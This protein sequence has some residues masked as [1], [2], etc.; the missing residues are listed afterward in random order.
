MALSLKFLYQKTKARY[1]LSLLTGKAGLSQSVSRIYQMEEPGDPKFLRGGELILTTGRSL[2]SPEALLSFVRTVHEKHACGIIFHMNDHLLTIPWDIITFCRDARFPLLTM[3]SD[4]SI[5]AVADTYCNELL[6][7]NAMDVKIQDAF[8]AI[9]L[10]GEADEEYLSFLYRAGYPEETSY[11]LAATKEELVSRDGFCFMEDAIHF[12]IIPQASGLPASLPAP[13]G[14]VKIPDIHSL[15]AGKKYA[16]EAFLI[17]TVSNRP[18]T[19]YNRIDFFR[20]LSSVSDRAKLRNFALPALQPLLDHDRLHGTGYLS[21]LRTYLECDGNVRTVS[22]NTATHYSTIDYRLRKIS[23][24]LDTD[25]TSLSHR[26]R[27]QTALYV[28][29]ALMLSGY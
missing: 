19:E 8:A 10:N 7:R 9:L 27:L 21:L 22:A 5:A 28:Y 1:R 3:P 15:A 29:D 18:L 23:G 11:F 12:L 2:S 26:C 13:S 14:F 24:L 16:Y 4:I 20:I 17:G 6:Q 25:M